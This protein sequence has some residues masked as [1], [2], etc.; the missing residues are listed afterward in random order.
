[1]RSAIL[2]LLLLAAALAAAMMAAEYPP[3][4]L[5]LGAAAVAVFLVTFLNVEAGL[6]IL[7]FA[8]LLSPEFVAGQTAGAASLGRGVTLRLDDF[9]LVI[10]GF[11]WLARNAV[12]KEIGMVARTPLNRPIFFYTFACLLSTTFGALVGR[13]DLKTGFFYV[14]KYFEYFIV[15][16]M[17]VNHA[18]SPRQIKR[19]VFCLLLTALLVSLYGI[20]QIPAGGRVSAP[21][22]GEY[23]EPNTFGGYLLFIMSLAA[24][25]FYTLRDVKVRAGLGAVIAAALPPFLYTGSRTS[26]LAMVA[27]VFAFGLLTR[28]K[29]LAVGLVAAGLILSPLFLPGAVKERVR[30]TFAQEAQRGQVAIGDVRL[31]TST[32]ARLLSWQEALKA[33]TRHPFLGHGVTGFRFI[34]GQFPRTLVETGVVGLACFLYLLAATWRLARDGLRQARSDFGRGLAIGFCVGFVGVVAHALGANTFVIVRIM[35]PFWFA[36]GAVT[37]LP[38]LEE[39]IE[40]VVIEDGLPA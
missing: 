5:V 38:G 15:Y 14:L 11:S 30:Y 12:Y 26:Y 32:S 3:R 39:G 1:M 19:F 33:W 13:V 10:I 23:G 31:D 6:Y 27:A 25:L 28:H 20:A 7:I 17:M 21:F 24:G 29:A 2:F 4:Q 35:E 40:A 36:A 37:V 18:E 9:L 16:F 22:E 34:D 8:M